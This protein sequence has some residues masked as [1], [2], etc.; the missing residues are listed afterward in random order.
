M[1]FSGLP[2]FFSILYLLPLLVDS[3]M[4]ES[5]HMFQFQGGYG[6]ASGKKIGATVLQT[7]T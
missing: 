3:Y 1:Y 6:M 2:F 7:I 4:R 5:I